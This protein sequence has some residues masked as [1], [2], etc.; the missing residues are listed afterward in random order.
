ML[1]ADCWTLDKNMPATLARIPHSLSS[2]A[3]RLESM[4]DPTQPL[5]MSRPGNGLSRGM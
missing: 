3:Y 1:D 4:D 5:M 2:I